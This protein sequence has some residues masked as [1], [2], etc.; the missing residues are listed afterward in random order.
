MIKSV[1]AAFAGAFGLTFRVILLVIL[2]CGGLYC[3]FAFLTLP[4]RWEGA[5][6]LG[7]LICCALLFRLVL[8]RR[9]KD[10]PPPEDNPR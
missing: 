1:L 2:T 5:S 9:K 3:L 10:S 4:F 6:W 8:G 7:G